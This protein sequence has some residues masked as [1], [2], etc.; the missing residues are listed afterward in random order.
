MPAA[1]SVFLAA[2]RAHSAN[3][4]WQQLLLCKSLTLYTEITLGRISSTEGASL[5][6]F[7]WT[8]NHSLETC[9]FLSAEENRIAALHYWSTC[10][11]HNNALAYKKEKSWVKLWS[12]TVIIIHWSVIVPGQKAESSHPSQLR[13]PHLQRLQ[14][15][16]ACRKGARQCPWTRRLN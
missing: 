12:C 3:Q 6:A 11:E 5:N 1:E 8:T 10:P 15:M 7:P 4:T 14:R 9:L 13:Q 2:C 16:N